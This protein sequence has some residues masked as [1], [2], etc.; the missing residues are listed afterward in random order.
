MVGNRLDLQ[1]LR[2]AALTLAALTIASVTV[3]QVDATPNPYASS[4]KMCF[5]MFANV[6]DLG[7]SFSVN[8]GR[9][10]AKSRLEALY[11]ATTFDTQTIPNMGFA[12]PTVADKEAAWQFLMNEQCNVI[13][14]IGCCYLEAVVW[15][16]TLIEQ[17]AAAYPNIT[18]IMMWD[19]QQALESSLTLPNL[20]FFIVDQT[21][22]YFL[23]GVAAATQ[24]STCTGMMVPFA[25]NRNSHDAASGFALGVQYVN[26][27]M[28]VHVVEM[29]SFYAPDMEILVTGL[30]E[31]RYGCEVTARYS[32]PRDV[33]TFVLSRKSRGFMSIGSHSDLQ[34]YVGDS[35][36]VSAFSHWDEIVVPLVGDLVTFGAIQPSR[37]PLRLRHSHRREW[38]LTRFTG[39][40]AC[41]ATSGRRR[42][43]RRVN[44]ER[45]RDVRCSCC[46]PDVLGGHRSDGYRH[47]LPPSHGFA[48]RVGCYA[49][50]RQPPRIPNANGLPERHF[51]FIQH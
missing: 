49:C 12:Y 43:C 37:L 25:W 6:D 23:A 36:L 19:D 7:W 26:A 18:F 1:M 20:V 17:R 9:L 38:C 44:S 33:D 39:G 30:L 11:P 34:Q 4:V 51:R 24:A 35:V 45:L 27:S 28:P 31:D 15:N 21:S 2:L 47:G 42:G 13:V 40:E 5:L 8:V 41:G 48:P 50:N 29:Q 10:R 3:V 16:R 22:A 32:D 46:V 14:S